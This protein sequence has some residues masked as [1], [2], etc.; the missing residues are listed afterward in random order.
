MQVLETFFVL[1]CVEEGRGLGGGYHE[2]ILLKMFTYILNHYV[3]S[4]SHIYII[5]V[6]QRN[7]T[8]L[9]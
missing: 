7:P 2:V 9:P 1:F 4:E 3:P 6:I 5:F 8:I